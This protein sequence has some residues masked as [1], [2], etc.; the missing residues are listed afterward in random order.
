MAER[1]RAAC[2]FHACD[3]VPCNIYSIGGRRGLSRVGAAACCG[4]FLNIVA[5]FVICCC[6]GC[7]IE[8]PRAP[9]GQEATL[10][11]ELR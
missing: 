8:K 5:R 3:V 9:V 6:S 4:I 11:M 2:V 1:M 7:E 10:A